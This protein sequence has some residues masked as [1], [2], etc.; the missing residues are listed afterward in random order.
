MPR[1]TDWCGKPSSN[2]K[3]GIQTKATHTHV[4]SISPCSMTNLSLIICPNRKV[5]LLYSY[6]KIGIFLGFLKKVSRIIHFRNPQGMR[7]H[8]GRIHLSRPAMA[9]GPHGLWSDAARTC[10]SDDGRHG[11]PR[12]PMICQIFE[13]FRSNLRGDRYKYWLVVSNMFYFL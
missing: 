5:Q 9:L 11:G 8:P 3:M 10:G 7:P 12:G 2:W 1:M 6:V 4:E 13:E